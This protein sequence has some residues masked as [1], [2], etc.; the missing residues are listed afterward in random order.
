[1]SWFEGLPW[2]LSRGILFPPGPASDADPQG[3]G[4]SP[5]G[6]FSRIGLIFL[7][8]FDNVHPEISLSGWKRSTFTKRN[9]MEKRF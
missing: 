1:M 4:L 5:V 8:L 6:W 7:S 3:F 9:D 2:I